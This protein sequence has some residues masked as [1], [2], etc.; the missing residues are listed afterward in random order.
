MPLPI[1]ERGL[2][3]G[4]IML[5]MGH[6]QKRFLGQIKFVNLFV[7][8][9]T[10]FMIPAPRQ[11]GLAGNRRCD[12]VLLRSSQTCGE[13]DQRSHMLFWSKMVSDRHSNRYFGTLIRFSSDG[14]KTGSAK[15][16]H[17]LNSKPDHWFSSATDLNLKPDLGP[18]L[19]GSGSNF[20][21]G[22]NRGITTSV[23]L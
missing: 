12:P 3:S 15:Y 18:V 20:R 17:P 10:T 21:S 9:P 14:F 19:P 11:T 4:I 7:K 2:R 13:T 22:P 16:C 23:G 6:V 8:A 1:V 5:S